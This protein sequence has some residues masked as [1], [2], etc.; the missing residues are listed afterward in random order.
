M[1]QTNLQDWSNKLFSHWN[2]DTFERYVLIRYRG[3]PDRLLSMYWWIVPALMVNSLYYLNMSTFCCLKWCWLT[4]ITLPE[5]IY[6]LSCND[7]K[8]T[9]G[10]VCPAKIQISQ[11]FWTLCL[12]SMGIFWTAKDAKF[13][14]VKNEDSDQ[15]AQ[16]CFLTLWLIL[17][18]LWLHGWFHLFKAPDTAL[19][20]TENSWTFSYFSMKTH[21]V[22]TYYKRVT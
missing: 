16:M 6:I 22:S 3:L 14:H 11:Q 13:F 20:L 17:L 4:K 21:V 5:W 15:T 19:F 9:F 1:T 7:R 10:H 8:C 12:E 18:G 2:I